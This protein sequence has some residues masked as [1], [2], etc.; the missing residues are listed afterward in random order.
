[1]SGFVDAHTHLVFA[2]DRAAEFA[3][4][5]AGARY[6]GGGIVA[7]GA[8]SAN[9]P[10]DRRKDTPGPVEPPATRP[11]SRAIVM[12]RSLLLFAELGCPDR[13]ACR[14]FRSIPV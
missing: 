9:R 4:R 11:D 2:G 10:D 13:A 14:C 5:M 7:T 12:P 6:D 1:V 8:A 3:A